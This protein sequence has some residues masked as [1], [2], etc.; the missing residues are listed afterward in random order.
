MGLSTS[1]PGSIR[2]GAETISF[3][4]VRSPRRKTACITVYPSGEVRLTVPARTSEAQARRYVEQKAGWVLGKL[5]AFEAQ[6][7]RDV[8]KRYVDGE[9]FLFLGREYA[10][11]ISRGPEPLVTLGDKTLNVFVQDPGD[12]EAIRSAVFGWYRFQAETYLREPVASYARALD[13][14]PPPFK[15]KNQSK[16]W[17]SCTAKNLLNFNLKIVMAPL[18]Q[19]EYVA[20]HEVCH[21]K[22]KDHSPRYWAVLKSIMPDCDTRKKALKTE[23]WKYEL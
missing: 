23:G 9:I 5:K 8:K 17:G 21:I 1:E 2:Y 15:V 19:L 20:A 22:V 12:R 13:V 10:L 3:S 18:E 4:I 11:Q 16:R 7:A 6:G 14:F